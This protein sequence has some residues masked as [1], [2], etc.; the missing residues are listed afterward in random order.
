M[1]RIRQKIFMELWSIDIEGG[2]VGWLEV[3]DKNGYLDADLLWIGGS[4]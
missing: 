1:H 2:A 3:H 4:V